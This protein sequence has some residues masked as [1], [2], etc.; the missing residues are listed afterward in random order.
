MRL[1]ALGRDLKIVVTPPKKFA[2]LNGSNCSR[3]TKKGVPADDGSMYPS[4]VI[5]LRAVAADGS[6]VRRR[7]QGQFSSRMTGATSELRRPYCPAV[8][9]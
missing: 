7:S 5:E 2:W 6:R 3:S 8:L 1:I 4:L 9:C